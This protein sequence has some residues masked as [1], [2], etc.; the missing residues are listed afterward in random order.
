MGAMTSQI[1]SLT[2]VYS[3]FCS[4]RSKKASTLRVTGLFEGNSPVTSE[5][6]A[7]RVSNTENVSIWCRHHVTYIDK[8]TLFDDNKPLPGPMLTQIY[9]Y[10]SLQAWIK[11]VKHTPRRETG[12]PKRH[13]F[14]E[15][16]SRR[17]HF[18]VRC[19]KLVEFRHY[20]KLHAPKVGSPLALAYNSVFHGQG[21]FGLNSGLWETWQ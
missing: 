4:R 1:T 21:A 19:R 9:V 10:I 20:A 18:H 7:Q 15:S 3:S 12:V 11:C 8:P 17:C 5:F 13:Y 2:I 16:T 6:P 14:L